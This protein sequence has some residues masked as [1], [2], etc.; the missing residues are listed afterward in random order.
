MHNDVPYKND[1]I[2]QGTSPW[3]SAG[4]LVTIREQQQYDCFI[5]KSQREDFT[6]LP[7]ANIGTML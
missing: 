5:V 2:R 7:H 6:M 3:T 4:K 1:P